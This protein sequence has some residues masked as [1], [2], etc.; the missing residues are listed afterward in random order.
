MSSEGVGVK[1]LSVSTVRSDYWM[2][3][4]DGTSKERLTYFNDP[5]APEYLGP[6]VVAADSAWSPDG[7]QVLAY[8]KTDKATNSGPLLLM[9]VD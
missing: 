1:G 6:W 5:S 7:K 9:D 8:V 4:A 2:M 3:K